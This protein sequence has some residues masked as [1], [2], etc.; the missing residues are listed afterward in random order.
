[1]ER[2]D[3]S[4]N[5]GVS[6]GGR[7]VSLEV[8]LIYVFSSLVAFITGLILAFNKGPSISSYMVTG[9]IVA[10]LVTSLL[11]PKARWIPLALTLGLHVGAI[12]TYYS[13]PLVLPLIIIERWGERSSLNIDVVQLI[14]AYEIVAS[15][16]SRLRQNLKTPTANYKQKG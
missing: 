13:N 10:Y 2:Q 5:E 12:T 7:G 1:M 4:N 15:V 8:T 14:L 3:G 6:G 9:G 16:I 11:I